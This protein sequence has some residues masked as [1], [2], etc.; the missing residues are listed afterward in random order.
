MEIEY[1]SNRSHDFAYTFR[2]WE[3]KAIAKALK[4]TLKRYDLLVRNI[5]NIPD[6]EGQV[7]YQVRI[8]EILSEKKEIE[9]IIKEFEDAN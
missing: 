1:S 5:E 4:K 7:K 9:Q 8:E 6:N 2:D 3:K